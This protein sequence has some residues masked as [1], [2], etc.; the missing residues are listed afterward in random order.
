MMRRD[1]GTLTPVPSPARGRG[2]S[3]AGGWGEGHTPAPQ[4]AKMP[5]KL[6][7]NGESC[8]GDLQFARGGEVEASSTTVERTYE[9][10]ER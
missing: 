9:V 7:E 3:A 5:N 8:S 10:M 2:V 4:N 1:K 6:V